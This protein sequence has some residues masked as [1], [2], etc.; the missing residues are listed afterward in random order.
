MWVSMAFFLL[1]LASVFIGKANLMLSLS[2][3]SLVFTNALLHI[4]GTIVTKKY[5]PGVIS[6]SL[7]YIPLTVYVYSV[8]LSSRHLTW[9]QAA[10]SFLLGVLYM[11]ALMAFVLIR[12]AGHND[13]QG[14]KV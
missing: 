4:R 5:Y 14:F 7:I 1:C 6:G 12:Q 3:F 2:V 8:F 10:L 9:L 13:K 11:G